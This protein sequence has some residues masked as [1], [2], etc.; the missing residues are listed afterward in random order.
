MTPARVMAPLVE[1]AC[2]A[3]SIPLYA[4]IV[5]VNLPKVCRL[6]AAPPTVDLIPRELVDALFAGGP[7]A[8]VARMVTATDEAFAAE[9]AS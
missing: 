2:I 4:F 9:V 6:F 1:V 5:V 8:M 3:A 7:D